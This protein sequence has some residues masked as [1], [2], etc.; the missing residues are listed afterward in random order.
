MLT[1]LMI[2]A[3]LLSGCIG[4]DDTLSCGE[5]TT[6]L[7][8]ECI[9]YNDVSYTLR[10]E[11]MAFIG[12][13]GSIDGITNPD[14]PIAVGDR[15]T[16]TLI[17]SESNLHD[18]TIEYYNVA[19]SQLTEEG[20]EDSLT[21]IASAEGTYAYYCSIPGHRAGGMEGNFIIG[22]G[23]GPSNFVE[24]QIGAALDVDTDNIARDPLDIPP[25]T[26][27][28]ET[29]DV[30][31]YME[32]VELVA[33]IQ[34]GTTFTYWTYNGTVP[35]PMFRA[36][37]GDTVFV[38]FSNLEENTMHH[39]VDFHSVTGQGGGAAAT[40]TAPG[41]TSVFSFKAM[42]PG[43]FVY[44]C[45][46]PD[47]P[48]HISKGMYGMMLI[49]P[50]IPLPPVDKEVYIMQ[51]DIY[52][53][54]RP[55]TEG[56]Q[57]FDDNALFEE[58]P[59][60]VVFNGKF[61][62]FTGEDTIQAEVGETMRI[63]FGVGGPNTISSFHLIG[64]IFDRVYNMGDLVSE[65]MQSV[66]TIAV[67]PGGA[68]VVDVTFDVPANYILVDHALTRAFHKGAVGII[69]VTGDEDPSVINEDA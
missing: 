37:V 39:N 22:T 9:G 58:S 4:S 48:T 6:L 29:A 66:Q 12:V 14:L 44:H 53:K 36:R 8:D 40:E 7:G 24:A 23:Q 31:I 43:L 28:N 41:T 59:T 5:G 16:L 54:W 50:E 42:H 47:I 46:T 20:S 69:A 52:T 64:E 30:H 62:T 3:P 2:C 33:E 19:T 63:Y 32:A 61:A 60:Y 1:G 57:E 25:P 34:S 55:G 18:V 56:H 38:H 68:V 65:P 21:F 67:V 26:G 27:R 10:A 11:N 35:G 49:E 15:V 51:G 45:A 13:G 17:M